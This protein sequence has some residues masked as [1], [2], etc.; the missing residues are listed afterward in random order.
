MA[1]PSVPIFYITGKGGVG[2]SS[3]AHA[4]AGAGTRRGL[5]TVV[6]EFAEA[7]TAGT[8]TV[9]E[10]VTH[11]V[12]DHGH[13]LKHLLTKLLH[14]DFLSQR[15]LDSRT[16][17][18]VAAAAPGIKDLVYLSW[19]ADLA[20]GA[21][22]N[23]GCDLI[24]VDGLASGHSLPLLAAPS[25]IRELATVGPASRI[26]R[27]ADMLVRG[28]QSLR[29][30]IVTSPEELSVVETL[31]LY[32]QLRE[33]G[34]SLTPP[35]INAMYP[36]LAQP[37]H[38]QWLAANPDASPDSNLY[39]TR[40]RRQS[41]LV[42]RIEKRMGRAATL[43]MNFRGGPPTPASASALLENLLGPET[44]RQRHGGGIG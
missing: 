15:L 4:L 38:A 23:P 10:G 3:V 11:I 30:V 17:S 18:A 41:E 5:R 42:T 35:V 13:A 19:L 28:E 8:N 25:R 21:T 29:V 22:D 1:T 33:I 24:I 39:L 34:V 12:I 6:V 36:Q 32:E 31:T 37:A 43:P 26:A 14:F 7:A 20:S 44:T 16:F 40:Y 27:D 2:K 9:D